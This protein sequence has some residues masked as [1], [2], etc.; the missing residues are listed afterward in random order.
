MAKLSLPD[1]SC[2]HQQFHVLAKSTEA[3]YTV[4]RTFHHYINQEHNF[5]FFWEEEDG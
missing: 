2:H 4:R 3:R 1:S 5:F